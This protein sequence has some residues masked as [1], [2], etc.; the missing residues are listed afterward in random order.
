LAKT[1]L[2][3]QIDPPDQNL[4]VQIYL[5][6]DTNDDIELDDHQVRAGIGAEQNV[7][8]L[9][10]EKEYA[11]GIIANFGSTGTT[12]TWSLQTKY[13]G[14]TYEFGDQTTNLEIVSQLLPYSKLFL[15]PVANKFAYIAGISLV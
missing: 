3:Y 13:S 8:V 2:I 11:Q 4:N 14:V 1:E 5:W 10:I 15:V 6:A 12:W 7:A 9:E